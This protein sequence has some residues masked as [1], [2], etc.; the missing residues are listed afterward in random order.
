MVAGAFEKMLVL[1]RH[2]HV[3]RPRLARIARC[4]RDCRKLAATL[5]LAASADHA[6]ARGEA[7]V[8]AARARAIPEHLL[9]I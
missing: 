5:D 3:L 7:D 1:G 8:R 6:R 2:R 9:A 4:A